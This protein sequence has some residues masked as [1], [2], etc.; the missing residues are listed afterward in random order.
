MVGSASVFAPVVLCSNSLAD[1]LDVDPDRLLEL[2]LEGQ[3]RPNRALKSARHG[4]AGL[5]RSRGRKKGAARRR[6][7]TNRRPA[8]SGSGVGARAPWG[9]GPGAS[10]QESYPSGISAASTGLG[11]IRSTPEWWSSATNGTKGFAAAEAK[12]SRV[13]WEQ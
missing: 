6:G 4:A 7:Q 8:G 13:A 5:R 3:C 11:G 9:S 1:E 10:R 2:L 12:A